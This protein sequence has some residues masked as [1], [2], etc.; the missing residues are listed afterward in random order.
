MVV[1]LINY[2]LLIYEYSATFCFLL[3]NIDL[4]FQDVEYDCFDSKLCFL[5]R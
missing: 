1:G 5:I 3:L 2:L 4:Y